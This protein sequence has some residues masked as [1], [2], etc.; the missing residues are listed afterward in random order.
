MQKGFHQVFSK[1]DICG[2]KFKGDGGKGTSG[3]LPQYKKHLECWT[4]TRQDLPEGAQEPILK[5]LAAL[6][7]NPG[8][9]E[10]IV[11]LAGHETYFSACELL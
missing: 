5:A 10:N 1:E 7:D 3:P 8:K 2:F 6:H 11:H 9:D 4:K